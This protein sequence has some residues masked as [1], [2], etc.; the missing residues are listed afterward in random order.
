MEKTDGLITTEEQ[1]FK[2]EQVLFTY[3]EEEKE[4]NNLNKLNANLI[5]RPQF[6]TLDFAMLHSGYSRVETAL[7][8][9]IKYFL[10][11]ND[12]FYCTNEQ[13]AEMLC[14]SENTITNA[15]AKLKKDW[16][17]NLTYKIKSSGWKIRFIRLT[18]SVVPTPKICGSE[19]QNLWGIYNKI[20]DNKIISKSKDLEWDY[21]EL[22][23]NYYWKNKWIDVKVCTKLINAK[24]KEWYTIQDIT[25]ALVLYNCECRTKW[26]DAYRY[27]KKFETWIKEFQPITDEDITRVVIQHKERM[28]TDSKYITWVWKIVIENLNETFGR[29]KIK[30]IW[31]TTNNKGINLRFT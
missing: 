20:I 1:W 5:L 15:V 18:K 30:E 28:D 24:L 23:N 8:G 14:V 31:K 21:S 17:I 4:E 16:L 2:V 9:F 25:N 19:T 11:N 22:F 29:D 7:Y 27:V 12:K 10:Y 26:A 6:L 13:L 3:S